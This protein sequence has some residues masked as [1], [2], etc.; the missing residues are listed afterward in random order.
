WLG[1]NRDGVTAEKVQPWKG[2]LKVLWKQSV[3]EG[4]SSPVVADG[5]VYLHTVQ[6]GK[7]IEVV[8]CHDAGTGKPLWQFEY[9]RPDFKA[10]FGRGP[11][12]TPAVIGGK[13]YAYGA[14]G[15]LTCLDAKTSDKLW[16]FDTR[17]EW[18]P[19]A[20]TFG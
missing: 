5:K 17:K 8:A 9:P 10:L 2:D 20:L 16:Q 4:H 15:I 7:E 11:R 3:G 6:P 19:P 1:P 18:S 14:T 13:V 12:A